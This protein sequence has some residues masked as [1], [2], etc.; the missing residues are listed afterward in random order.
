MLVIGRLIHELAKKAVP[1]SNR[2]QDHPRGG[3]RSKRNRPPVS[4]P[5]IAAGAVLPDPCPDNH[6][7]ARDSVRS[8]SGAARGTTFASRMLTYRPTRATRLAQ[9]RFPCGSETRRR[10][11]QSPPRQ[12]S[13]GDGWHGCEFVQG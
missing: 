12:R 3:H 4:W 1:T 2:G 5:P 9:V 10:A 7:V 8:A 11:S 6:P 13:T